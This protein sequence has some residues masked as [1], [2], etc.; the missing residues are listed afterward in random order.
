[1]SSRKADLPEPDRMNPKL[2]QWLEGCAA[3][4]GLLG[5]SV[6]LADGTY[7]SQSFSENCPHE[8]LEE[9]LRCLGDSLPSF[10]THGLMPRWLTWNFENGRIRLAERADGLLLGI[11]IQPNSAAAEKLDL[12]TEEFF[13]LDL[14]V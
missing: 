11:A 8:R 12:F 1:M 13:N 5:G 10:S 7:V 14:T 2:K 6:R 3:A 4:P 9:A